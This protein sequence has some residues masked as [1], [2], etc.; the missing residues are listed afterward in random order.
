MHDFVA[1]AN[2]WP[3]A[4]GSLLLRAALGPREDALAAWTKYEREYG[5]DHLDEAQFRL[6]PRVHHHLTALGSTTHPAAGKLKAAHRQSWCRNQ[7]MFHRLA[8]ALRALEAEG[9]PSMVLKGASLSVTAY[10]DGGAR[11]MRDSD[12]L[13]PTRDAARA[14]HC[15]AAH[16]WRTAFP[17]RSPLS[18]TA[19]RSRHAIQLTDG[20]GGEIDLHWHML[21][22]S[23][24]PNADH[25]FW[26]RAV[27]V[28][29]AGAQTRAPS[30]E[31]QV[32]HALTHGLADNPIPG[33][34]WIADTCLAMTPELN[35]DIVIE[36]AER[37]RVLP[38]VRDG[39]TYLATEFGAPVHAGVLARLARI[40]VAASEELEY[41]RTVRS[42]ECFTL[43]QTLAATY[44][45]Y[46]R[47]SH[48]LGV[49]RRWGG[50]PGYVA[51]HWQTAGVVAF[52]A[53]FGRWVRRRWEL[54]T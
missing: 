43:R 7:M 18:G 9:I 39:L 46:L 54:A 33:I 34:R 2:C 28:S 25:G 36:E 6:L 50:F 20:A 23:R 52:G 3:G 26:Q 24:T 19:R 42:D 40:H 14:F 37:H 16:G 49:L 21:F 27:P 8:A 10:R 29:I 51:Q 15:L 47:G 32:L 35:W 1:R 38:W 17:V 41:H 22:L 4:P 30:A 48:D 31:D 45:A 12:V 5:L 13:V 11:P 53:A 44:Q